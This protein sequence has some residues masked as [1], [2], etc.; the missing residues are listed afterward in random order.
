M[1]LLQIALVATIAAIGMANS[2]NN[3]ASIY[4]DG[5]DC[6]YPGE[7]PVCQ[8][9]QC[10]GDTLECELVADFDYTDCDYG[11]ENKPCLKGQCLSGQCSLEPTNDG[12]ACD[13]GSD[14]GPCQMGTCNQ[15]DCKATP[16]RKGEVCDPDDGENDPCKKTVCNDYGSCDVETANE[17]ADDEYCGWDQENQE[18]LYC[19]GG[20]CE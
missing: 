2:T 5:N 7:T 1:K 17:E 12:A 10:Q 9:G 4:D 18:Y 16:F 3:C 14:L 20:E 11:G 15:G 13:Y 19:S 6:N 8:K